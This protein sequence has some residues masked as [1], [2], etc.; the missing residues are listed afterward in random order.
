MVGRLA[1]W[2][3][4]LG[5][6]TLYYPDISDGDLLKI[7]I[8]D[9][10]TILTKDSHFLKRKNLG[11]LFFV[12]SDDPKEQMA[13]V[14]RGFQIREFDPG[15]CVLCNGLLGKVG[16]KD[17]IKD[18]VPEYVFLSSTIFFRCHDCGKIYWDGTHL[19]KFR[20]MIKG[21]TDEH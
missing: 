13:E 8:R 9:V 16:M 12:N 7:A 17:E 14:I 10:R 11:N 19:K 20:D 1:R 4:L 21:I 6:D 18:M 5:F 2:L 3:R 15:R